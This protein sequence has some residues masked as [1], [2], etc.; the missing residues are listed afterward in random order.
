MER[1]APRIP[2]PGPQSDDAIRER[3]RDSLS[4]AR[5]SAR[6]RSLRSPT[7]PQSQPADHHG[8]EP[9]LPERPTGAASIPRPGFP[10]RPASDPPRATR[11][12][13]TPRSPRPPQ[14]DAPCQWRPRAC[15]SADPRTSPRQHDCTRRR[16]RQGPWSTRRYQALAATRPTIPAQAQTPRWCGNG[17]EPPG[18]RPAPAMPAGPSP[19]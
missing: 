14:P 8:R 15:R 11:G 2:L 19:H 5:R 13:S 18:P 9:P 3:S 1:S 7:P 6:T 10:T 16:S 12:R 17:R 4:D